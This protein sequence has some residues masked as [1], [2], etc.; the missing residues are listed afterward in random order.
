MNTGDAAA[1]LCVLLVDDNPGDR[2]LAC[3]RLE[4]AGGIFDIRCAG[5]LREAL[6]CLAE[7]PVDIILL[8]LGLPDSQGIE[9]FRRLQAAIPELPVVILTGAEDDAMARAAL[10]AGAQD[11][12]VK[13]WTDANLTGRSLRYAVERKRLQLQLERERRAR[14]LEREEASQ[15]WLVGTPSTSVTARLFGQRPL[16]EA[17]P[18]AFEEHLQQYSRSIRLALDNRVTNTGHAVSERMRSIAERMG[19]SLAGPRD[20]VDLHRAAMAALCEGANARQVEAYTDEGRLLLLE[21]MGYLVTFYRGYYTGLRRNPRTARDET[22][23]RGSE[24]NAS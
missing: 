5:S 13:D 14:E 19:S 2:D 23:I 15:Q 8:D 12:L 10:N 20:I 16:R 21:L 3:D 1:P 18:A 11:Y 7:S 9:T 22:E 6:D 4:H 24:G 17:S